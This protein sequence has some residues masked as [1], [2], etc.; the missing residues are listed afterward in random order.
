MAW[1]Q[2]SQKKPCLRSFLCSL[3]LGSPTEPSPVGEQPRVSGVGSQRCRPWGSWSESQ[4]PSVP[5]S[6]R[7]AMHLRLPGAK[8]R[9]QELIGLCFLFSPPLLRCGLIGIWAPWTPEAFASPSPETDVGKLNKCLDTE[10]GDGL[11][12]ARILPLARSL[13]SLR[14]CSWRQWGCGEERRCSAWLVHA[15]PPGC[16]ARGGAGW[17]HR[18]QASEYVGLT[19]RRWF[20]AVEVVL[21]VSLVDCKCWV[22]KTP[23]QSADAP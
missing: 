4:P 12:Q 8:M 17:S 5:V 23:F 7:S 9:S 22:G 18:C 1:A 13:D 20:E 21:W 10:G 16:R 14:P 15:Y 6:S 19:A 11:S 2:K 3:S